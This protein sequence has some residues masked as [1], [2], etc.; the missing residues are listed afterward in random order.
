MAYDPNSWE[1]ER[2][3]LANLVL[4]RAPEAEITASRRNYRALRLA[5]YIKKQLAE[6]PPLSEEQRTRIAD[7]LL[8]GG[9]R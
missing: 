3:R 1:S 2:G 8:A 4:S 7:L 5:E 6:D 9:T